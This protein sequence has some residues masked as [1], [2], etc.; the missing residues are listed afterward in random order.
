MFQLPYFNFPIFIFPTFPNGEFKHF[1]NPGTLYRLSKTINI[2]DSR[3]YKNNSF[4]STFPHFLYSL[5]FFGIFKSI[6]SWIC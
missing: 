4:P 2:V 5:K 3:I 1:K 6:K